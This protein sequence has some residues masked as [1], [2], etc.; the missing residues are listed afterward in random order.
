MTPAPGPPAYPQGWQPEGG[1]RRGHQPHQPGQAY[2][3][4][5]P[6]PAEDPSKR[7]VPLGVGSLI[8][9]G[10]LGLLLGYRALASLLTAA[11]DEAQR[12]LLP[13]NVPA[14]VA[15][16]AD[17]MT[18]SLRTIANLELGCLVP[19]ALSIMVLFVMA[20]GLL[21]KKRWA[22]TGTMWWSGLGLFAAGL[23]GALQVI[24]LA[25]EL[26]ALERTLAKLTA[27]GTATIT[28]PTM[29][30][31]MMPVVVLALW[32][33]AAFAWAWYVDQKLDEAG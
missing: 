18:S 3:W 31:T 5:E 1:A 27:A 29:I 25:P 7:M 16:L 23:A 17:Q 8:A 33:L 28:A 13:G 2:G 10:L 11:L 32:A 21:N 22:V 12:K 4:Q 19:I 26:Q 20:V 14:S 30:R 15:K 6:R 9:A 24:F